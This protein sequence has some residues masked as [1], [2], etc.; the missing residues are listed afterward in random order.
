MH[1]F[2]TLPRYGSCEERRNS[3]LAIFPDAVQFARYAH[4][5]YDKNHETEMR[6]A[7]E[8]I[9]HLG[10][11]HFAYFDEVGRHYAELRVD[12]ARGRAVL[13]F[14]G[15]RL[16]VRSDLTTNVLNFVGVETRYH[17]WAASLAARIERSNLE[18]RK[19]S[20]TGSPA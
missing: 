8:T 17:E 1:V 18:Q 3:W 10:E 5:V 2:K 13:I 15:T 14:R 7:R 20:P 6:K 16:D 19:S 9:R 12:D 4:D 11:D